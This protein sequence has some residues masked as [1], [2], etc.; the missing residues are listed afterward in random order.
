[1]PR[2]VNCGHC[3]RDPTVRLPRVS[4]REQ[5]CSAEPAQ[6]STRNNAAILSHVRRPLEAFAGGTGLRDETRFSGTS[7][8]IDREE[9]HDVET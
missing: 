6:P 5:V 2:R 3:R 4:M 7:M 9:L 8:F 1:V